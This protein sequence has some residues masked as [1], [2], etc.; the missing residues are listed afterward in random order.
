MISINDCTNFCSSVWGHVAHLDPLAVHL[1]VL[2]LRWFLGTRNKFD[3]R[4]TAP[5]AQKILWVAEVSASAIIAV[6]S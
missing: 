5:T 2:K 6:V 1:R 4:L 3:A